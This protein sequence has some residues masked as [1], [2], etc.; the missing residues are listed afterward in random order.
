MMKHLMTHLAQAGFHRDGTHMDTVAARPTRDDYLEA[1]IKMMTTEPQKQADLPPCSR[2]I[3]TRD[4][5]AVV[6]AAEGV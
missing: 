5:T 6:A 1:M 4:G 3:A 2:A